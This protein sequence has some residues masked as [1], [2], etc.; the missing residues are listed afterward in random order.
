MQFTSII[1]YFTMVEPDEGE[2]GDVTNEEV[3]RDNEAKKIDCEPGDN[4]DEH[5]VEQ[6]IGE[7]SSPEQNINNIVVVSEFCKIPV[8]YLRILIIM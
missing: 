3:A 1:M 6:D 4:P 7:Q 2:V 5:F 8:Q